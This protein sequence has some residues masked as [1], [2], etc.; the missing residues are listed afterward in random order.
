M[1][2]RLTIITENNKPVEALGENPEE[3]VKKAWEMIFKLITPFSKNKD[4]AYVENVEILRGEVD[5]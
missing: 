1:K 2:I 4:K 5:E 3:A